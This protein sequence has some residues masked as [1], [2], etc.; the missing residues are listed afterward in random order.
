MKTF[1]SII[2]M[3]MFV[4]CMTSCVKD[5]LYDGVGTISVV[6]EW[7]N[8]S[9]DAVPATNDYTMRLTWVAG[10]EGYRTE[11]QIVTTDLPRYTFTAVPLGEYSLAAYTT[12]EGVTITG[13]KASINKSTSDDGILPC[14]QTL[15]SCD[16]NDYL[17]HIYVTPE[18][19]SVHYVYFYQ[20]MRR[21][22]LV[23]NVV[24]GDYSRIA[25]ATAKISG[26]Y[27]SANFIARQLDAESVTNTAPATLKQSEA[28]MTT[29]YNLF[30]IPGSVYDNMQLEVYV[31]FDNGDEQTIIGDINNSMKGFGDTYEPLTI[32]ADLHLPVKGS[33]GGSI[34]GWRVANG[35]DIDAQ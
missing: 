13:D 32:Y 15:F 31:L 26:V 33:F 23:L 28:M 6:S 11:T 34:D 7:K 17:T 2:I 19:T 9:A 35:G 18:A 24:E 12:P 10:E 22:Y 8:V 4:L 20:M 16:Y 29:E 30:A 14:P 5:K 25:K 1:N 3:C 21:L 27:G